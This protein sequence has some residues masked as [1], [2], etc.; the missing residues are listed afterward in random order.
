MSAE[1]KNISSRFDRFVSCW[2]MLGA[3]CRDTYRHVNLM[4]HHVVGFVLKTLLVLYFLFCALF[5]TLRYGILP[6]IDHYKS[7]VEQ[8]ASQALGNSITIGAIAASWHGLQPSLT[9]TDVVLH[10]KQNQAALRLPQVAT[11]VSWRSL[12]MG[13]VHLASLEID[14]PDLQI[15]RDVQGN[16]FVAGVWVNNPNDK[17][18]SG[19]DWVFS[20]RQI[21]IRHG[22][23]RWNDQMRNAPE[24]T[25]SDVNLALNNSWRSHQFALYATPPAAFAAPL[26]LQGQFVHPLFTK[27][28][29]DITRWKGTLYADV[30][31]TALMNWKPYFDYPLD[32]Q[33]G[34][35]SVRTW[36]DV[37]ATKIIHVTADVQL[38]NLSARLRQD[39]A[40]L[41]LAQVSGRISASENQKSLL[42]KTVEENNGKLTFGAYCH[43]VAL[44]DF[45]LETSDGLTLP[46]TTLKE[47][48][49]PA[50]GK[51]AEK[52]MVSATQIDLQ[53]IAAFAQRLPLTAAQLQLLSKLAP[54]GQLTD[55][56]AEWQGAYP[57]IAAYH[58]QGKFQ[59]FS[60]NAQPRTVLSTASTAT[61][62]VTSNTA[63]SA[64][65]V[66]TQGIPSVQNLSGNINVNEKGGS[67]NLDSVK[68]TLLLPGLFTQPAMPFTS[69]KMQAHWE[70]LSATGKPDLSLTIANMTFMQDGLSGE[71]SGNVVV[72]L[73]DG[74]VTAPG[75]I[76]MTAKLLEF[77][78]K[79]L[80]NY[81][82]LHTPEHLRTW[83]VGAIQGG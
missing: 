37:D 27:K 41:E 57:L 15:V 23:V 50:H 4:T 39:L 81:L 66:P 33:Q 2:R 78:T 60:V 32:L 75:V 19:A 25:L 74:H 35:G 3:G 17:K 82:P 67:L 76:D 69:L 65:T 52:F 11:T 62:P 36:L 16:I 40:P 10:D 51:Q 1:Q 7:N 18:G 30:R 45:S 6:N 79:K 73:K 61:A 55:F 38:S 12:L 71:L 72:P 34:A 43:S 59:G 28:I 44:T 13:T 70:F 64:P 14:K 20:Q 29:A 58:V 47:T 48:Y 46:R 54:R 5:L 31:N 56:S 26:E 77:D 53:T 8:L 83:L 21:V 22:S 42:Q 24:L 9:L 63:Q 49:L 68:T 80:A